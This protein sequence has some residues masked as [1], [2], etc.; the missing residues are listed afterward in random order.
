MNNYELKKIYYGLLA[1]NPDYPAW[2]EFELETLYGEW[3]RVVSPHTLWLKDTRYRHNPRP[4]PKKWFP[5]NGKYFISVTINTIYPNSSPVRSEAV[6]NGLIRETEEQAE[7]DLRQIR[8][9]CRFLAWR[10]EFYPGKRHVDV[11]D[12]ALIF[13]GREAYSKM[14]ES[15]DSGELEF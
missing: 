15:I 1:D 11:A 6:D 8:Q 7:Q 3:D 12:Y 10:A 2:E 14:H 13:L 5:K 4:K 9:F